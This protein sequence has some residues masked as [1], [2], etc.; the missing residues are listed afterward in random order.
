MNHDISYMRRALELAGQGEGW[1]EPNPMVGCLIVRDDRVVAEGFHR[2]FGGPHAEIDA[3]SKIHESLREAT[4]YVTLEPCCHHGKTPPCSQALIAARP[5]R[6]VVALQDPFP[7]VAGGGLQQLREAG[8]EVTTGVLESECRELLAPYLKRVQTGKPWII[9]KWAMSLDGRIATRTGSSQWIS[10][11]R[12]REVVHQLRGRVDGILVGSL[13]A[14]HDNPLLTARPAGPRTATRIVLDSKAR[15]PLDS[16]LVQSIPQAP[17]LV[18]AGPEARETSLA[19]LRAHGAEVLGYEDRDRASRLQRLLAELGS[20]GMTNLL[21]EGGAE[22]L[23][24]LADLDEIDEAWAFIAPK[25]IGGEQALSPIRGL[26]LEQVAQAKEACR[27]RV[28][29][30]AGDVWVRAI[31]RSGNFPEPPSTRQGTEG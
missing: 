11:E 22:V 31:W 18:V 16:R 21:V 7:Q 10:N 24:C 9:A 20:R 26:G 15:L 28:T 30:L 19:K 3:L 17:V 1:V 29:E 23:G 13:T 2:R 27:V 8:I 4:V 6:V 12:S 5:R 25:L 14:L